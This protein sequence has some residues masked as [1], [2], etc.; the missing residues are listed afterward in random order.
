MLAADC[1]AAVARAV[2][3]CGGVSPEISAAF[4]ASSVAAFWFTRVNEMGW[5]DAKL[6]SAQWF[7]IA[8]RLVAGRYFVAD[9]GGLFVISVDFQSSIPIMIGSAGPYPAISAG[10]DVTPETLLKCCPHTIRYMHYGCAMTYV[11]EFGFTAYTRDEKIV[12]LHN[13]GWSYR[14]IGAVTGLSAN[15]VMHALRRITDG[16][17]GS[18]RVRQ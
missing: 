4:W 14:R 2:F 5:I 16:G 18:G 6:V 3:L 7:D 10:I 1:G 15:G 13:M 11:D 9:P 17:L 8:G 12:E